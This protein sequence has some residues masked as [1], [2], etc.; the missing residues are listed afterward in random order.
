MALAF[1]P[2]EV[3]ERLR[4]VI[5][6]GDRRKIA[7][8]GGLNETIVDEEFNPKEIRT[9]AAHT[10]LQMAS[11]LSEVCEERGDEFMDTLRDLYELSKMRNTGDSPSVT[12]SLGH[13]VTLVGQILADRANGNDRYEQLV[14]SRMVSRRMREIC[15]L[16]LDEMAA[17]PKGRLTPG[18]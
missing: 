15:T 17:Q 14:K 7:V 12:N 16:L 3:K 1:T 2:E 5:K 9:S 6:H 8:K 18:R 11:A 10:M 4:D 13:V